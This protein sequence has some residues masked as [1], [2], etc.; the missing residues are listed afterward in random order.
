M[1]PKAT[2][3][4]CDD[5]E[6]GGRSRRRGPLATALGA[7]GGGRPTDD[8][9]GGRPTDDEVGGRAYAT[10]AGGG[11]VPERSVR[12]AVSVGGVVLVAQ[13]RDMREPVP[14]KSRRILANAELRFGVVVR[15]GNGEAA[16]AEEGDL[17][18]G[19][20][21]ERFGALD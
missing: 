19:A 5:E 2:E 4:P 17:G 20:L 10:G 11:L 16:S 15:S 9:V 8:K 1:L 18:L 6:E 13:A 21:G 12:D 14:R 7:G 3:R